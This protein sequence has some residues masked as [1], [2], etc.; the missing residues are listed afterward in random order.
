MFTIAIFFILGAALGLAGLRLLLHWS[1]R[2]PV[3]IRFDRLH[4][5][6]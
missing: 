5:R 6:H 1:H 4:R 3:K 2:P